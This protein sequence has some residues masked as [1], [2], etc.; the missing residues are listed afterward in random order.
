MG[1][2]KSLVSVGFGGLMAAGCIAEVEQAGPDPRDVKPEDGSELSS[3]NLGS[4]EQP[5]ALHY[6]DPTNQWME[7][8]YPM[9]TDNPNCKDWWIYDRYLASRPVIGTTKFTT[10]ESSHAWAQGTYVDQMMSAIP[11]SL[12]YSWA[13]KSILVDH[14][15]VVART[16][17]KCSGRYVFQWDNRTNYGPF[18]KTQYWVSANIPYYLIPGNKAACTSTAGESVPAVMVDLYACEAP[19]SA[20]VTSVSSWCSKTNG[21]WRKV[22]SSSATGYWTESL[23][24]CSAAT[25][26]F[27][28]TPTDRVAVSF[29][30]VVKAGIGH[31]VAP[32]EIYVIRYN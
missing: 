30:M 19:S 8:S 18:E 25:G 21:K 27:Y 6:T 4:A 16:S 9:G 10:Y 20:S 28:P 15:S 23:K 3:A 17:G 24:R 11:D 7:P 14:N 13:W 1:M 31:G 32:A 12:G 29:N 5:H 22:G 2:F 26:V